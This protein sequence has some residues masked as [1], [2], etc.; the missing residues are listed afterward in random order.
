MDVTAEAYARA[1]SSQ[2]ACDGIF[3]LEEAH[4][5]GVF[6]GRAV[7]FIRYADQA[8]KGAALAVWGKREARAGQPILGPGALAAPG[9]RQTGRAD[10]G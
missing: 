6:S 8:P 7:N 4:R 3:A 9:E 2:D 10:A 1:F 5:E